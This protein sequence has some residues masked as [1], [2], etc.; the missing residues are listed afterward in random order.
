M[1]LRRAD[2]GEQAADHSL[3][4]AL[5]PGDYSYIIP[6]YI[7]QSGPIMLI[8]DP[9]TLQKLADL[10]ERSKPGHANPPTLE[11]YREAIKIMRAG[12]EAVPQ[13]TAGT[14]ARKTAA[15][16]APNGDDLLSQLEGL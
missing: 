6:R 16:T 9:Q 8:N 5:T 2:T 14:K 1:L 13:A 4:T 11:E 15:K 7:N 12:R 3:K 10:R